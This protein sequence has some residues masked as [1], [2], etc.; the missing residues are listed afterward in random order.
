MAE[1]TPIIVYTAECIG[2]AA[3]CLYPNEVKITDEFSAKLAFATDMVCARYKNNYVT[4]EKLTSVLAENNGCAAVVSAEGGIHLK[5]VT[6]WTCY[7]LR[8]EQYM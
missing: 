3:N 4:S 5:F 1:N 8:N 6:I 2:N 7:I